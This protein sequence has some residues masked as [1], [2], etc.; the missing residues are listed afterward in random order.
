M[1]MSMPS[2]TPLRLTRRAALGIL[3]M[4]LL[5][6]AWALDA[7]KGK[8]VLSITGAITQRN[9]ADRADFDMAMLSALPQHSF[10]AQTPWFKTPRKFTGPLLRDVLA[11]AGAKGGTLTAVALNDYKVELPADDASKFDVVMARLMDDEPMPIRDKGPLFIVYPF[12]SQSLL[13][14][15]RYYSRSAW[16]LRTLDV[17]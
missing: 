10:S 5:L 12:D 14:S 8:V 17:K 7:P 6:P 9:A 15:E 16:Q 13:R 3:S 2:P 4:L 11:A 1:P